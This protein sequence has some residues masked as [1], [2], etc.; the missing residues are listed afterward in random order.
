V[1][2]QLQKNRKKDEKLKGG[3]RK[4]VGISNADFSNFW[5]FV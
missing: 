4:E 3:L 2:R 5:A 1:Q